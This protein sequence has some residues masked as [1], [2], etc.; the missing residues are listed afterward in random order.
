MA[1]VERELPVFVASDDRRARRLRRIVFAAVGLACLWLGGLGIGMVGLDSLPRTTIGVFERIADVRNDPEPSRRERAREAPARAPVSPG[2]ADRVVA[3]QSGVRG[4]ARQR[5]V[6]RP[7]A[8]EGSAVSPASPRP[9]MPE[10]PAA[11]PPLP[12]AAP[13]PVPRQGWAQRGYTV[14]PGQTIKTE[15]TLQPPPGERGRRVGQQPLTTTT[16]PPPPPPGNG[17]NPKK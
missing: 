12:P 8:A 11:V 2:A 7:R 9:A 4:P 15:T 1:T 14:P 17:N 10:P 13:P 3:E 6:E 16:A 5:S